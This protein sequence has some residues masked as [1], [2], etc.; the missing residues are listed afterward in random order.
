MSGAVTAV[1]AGPVS[2]PSP[3]RAGSLRCRLPRPRRPAASLAR[4]LLALILLAMW[5][6]LPSADLRFWMS[7]PVEIVARLW[8]WILDG[9]LWEN[10]GATLLAMVAGLCD[11]HR[12]R[13]RARVAVRPDAAAASRA[14]A[15]HH[16]AVRDAEDRTGAAVRHRVRHR[17]RIEGGAGRHHRVLPGAEQHAGRRAQCRSRPDA[18]AGADGGDAVRGDRARCWCRR[19]CRGSSPACGSRSATPSPTRCWPS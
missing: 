1:I 10:V 11:R 5:E 12:G 13:H 15:L 9:S 18:R 17:P 2:R 4:L 3:A 16:G 14:V 8:S 6:Y 7:G 19:R